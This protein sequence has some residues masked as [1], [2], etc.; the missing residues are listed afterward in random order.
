MSIQPNSVD[1]YALDE[2]WT[3]EQK[4]ICEQLRHFVDRELLPEIGKWT[5]TATVP[6]EIISKI[7]EFG[8]LE[9]LVRRLLCHPRRGLC[10]VEKRH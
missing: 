8:I 9:I 4:A 1:L 5:E 3:D 7:A 10:W 2:D 6:R